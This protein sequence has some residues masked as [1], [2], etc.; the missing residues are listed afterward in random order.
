M[1]IFYLIIG[2]IICLVGGYFIGRT[3]RLERLKRK[4]RVSL[5]K[6]YY[7]GLNYLI[8]EKPDDAIDAFIQLLKVDTETVDTHLA[9]GHLFRKQGEVERAIRIHQNIIAR[10]ELKSAHKQRALLAL[11]EDYMTAGMYDRAERIYLEMIKIKTLKPACADKL[12]RLYQIEQEWQKAIDLA[13]AMRRELPN[14]NVLLAHF[15]CELA[16]RAVLDGQTEL[17]I[18]HYLHAAKQADSKNIRALINWAK[19]EQANKEFKKA[20]QFFN[21][22]KTMHQDFFAMVLDDMAEC[23]RQLNKLDE[24]LKELEQCYHERH[25]PYILLAIVKFMAQTQGVRQ[26]VNY[27][28]QQQLPASLL[29]LKSL[30]DYCHM[31]EKSQVDKRLTYAVSVLDTILLYKP[32]YQCQQCGYTGQEFSWDCPKC[33]TWESIKPIKYVR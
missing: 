33:Y 29:V 23:Y 19:R 20:I 18:D 27:L 25:N 1:F 24:F 2:A 4:F 22:I 13:G 17:D 32:R 14:V 10:P 31:L 11:A 26:A 7:T 16:E 8:D 15:Y 6:D 30:L 5:A 21:K 28:T 9:L 12:L 3:T